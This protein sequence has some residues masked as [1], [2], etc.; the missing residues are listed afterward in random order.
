MLDLDGT[1]SHSYEIEELQEIP[2][3]GRLE[4]PV[5][6]FPRPENRPE[7]DGLWLKI[8]AETGNSWVGVFA[9][10]YGSPPAFSRLFSSPD[11]GKVCVV[12]RGA[13]YIVRADDPDSWEKIPIVPVLDIRATPEHGFLIFADHTRLAAYGRAGLVW[14]SPR[15]CWDE[16]KIVT[17]TPDRIDGVGSDPTNLDALRPFA[18]DVRTG[19]SLLPSPVSTDH[20]PVW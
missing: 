2:G 18:V 9:F 17:L 6:Y 5:F 8:R 4:V 12:S 20:K 1:Y 3:T 15:V 10:G 11:P 14:R 19:R 13:A 7:H 16:L